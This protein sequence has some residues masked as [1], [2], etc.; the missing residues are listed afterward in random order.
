MR[1]LIFS[2]FDDYPQTERGCV[3]GNTGICSTEGHSDSQ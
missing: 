1:N 2:S 3:R